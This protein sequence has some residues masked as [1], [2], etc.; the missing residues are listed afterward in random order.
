M[1]AFLSDDMNTNRTCN[2]ISC[3]CGGQGSVRLLHLHLSELG[4]RTSIGG[5]RV[6]IARAYRFS[7]S[8][9]LEEMLHGEDPSRYWD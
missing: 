7:S 9:S 4:S 2:V 6:I 8:F 1:E 5:F 3:G